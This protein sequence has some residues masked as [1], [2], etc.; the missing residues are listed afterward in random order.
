MSPIR[1][2]EFY[3]FPWKTESD[4]RKEGKCYTKL[5]NTYLL[6][7]RNTMYEKSSKAIFV[8]TIYQ[9]NLSTGN[10]GLKAWKK[11]SLCRH[12]KNF[13]ITIFLRHRTIYSRNFSIVFNTKT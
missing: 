8:F 5:T 9:R 2:G 1:H 11:V 3:D 6:Q 13:A 12:D 10:I 4:L 7:Y